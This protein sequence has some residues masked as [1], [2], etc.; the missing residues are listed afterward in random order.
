MKTTI[1]QLLEDRAEEHP[2]KEAVIFKGRRITYEELNEK[3]ERLAH[4]LMKRGI[5]R[6]DKVAIWLPNVPEWIIAWFAIPKIGAVV[7]P[8]DPWYKG[9]E[10]EYM[11]ND[12]DT[13][14]V[15]TTEESG[16]YDFL[17]IL[18]DK[19]SDLDK[20][21]TVVMIDGESE[22]FD[23]F[24]FDEVYED[25]KDWEDNDEYLKRKEGTDPDDV[26]FIL[27]T[28]GT[29]G[30]PKGVMLSHHQIVKNAHDQGEILRTSADDKL[31]IPVPFSHCFGNVMSITLMTVFGGTM[32]PL[33]EFEPHKAL[34][35]VENEGATMIHG[36][37]TMFIRELEVIKEEDY[38]TSSLRTGI[39]AGSSCPVETMKLVINDLGCNVS[40]TYGLTEASP[41]VTMTRFDD[42]VQ[43]RVETVGRVMPDQEIKIVDEEGNEVPPGETGELLVKGYNVMKGYYNK[44][45]E[46]ERTIED[47]WLHTGDLAEM[48][49]RGYVEI[50]GRKKDMVIVGGLNVYPREIEEYLI[51]NPEIQEVAVVGVPDEELGEVVAAAVVPTEGADLAKQDVVDFLYGEV[52]SA[53]VPRYVSITDSLP[54]SGRGKVQKFRL[55][56][57]LEEMME[58]GELQ[59]IVPSEVKNK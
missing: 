57:Q 32:I 4:F 59:K 46:T 52:A 37:P 21:E 38:D 24:S 49:E 15:I 42:S 27:Y 13:K 18:E 5:G 31:V 3:A 50:V 22:K 29:T 48:D 41:G 55:R 43:D 9:G 7:V 28:S 16:K 30:K 8:T 39:M 53:K 45:E 25:G 11:F 19:K 10:I 34:E 58:E 12:S 40:I 35:Q 44:P 56:D 17:D 2:D 36:V 20:L 6:D 23:S 14:A 47:G 33:V 26:T 54:V 51:E 1:G